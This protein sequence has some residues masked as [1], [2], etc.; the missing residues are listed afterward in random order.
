[1]ASETVRVLLVEDGLANQKLAVGMLNRWGHTVTVAENGAVGV[2]MYQAGEFDLVFMDLQMPVMDGL[3]ATQRIRETEA[4]TENH[5]PI[6]AMTAHALVGDR[7]R[8]IKAGMDHY[9]SKPIRI[10]DLALAIGMFHHPEQ[11]N[12]QTEEIDVPSSDISPSAGINL[13]ETLEMMEDDRSILIS[14]VQAFITEAPILLQ[15]FR[16][17][18]EAG[19]RNVAIRSAHTLKGNFGILR[20]QAEQEIWQQLEKLAREGSFNEMREPAEQAHN[21]SLHVLKQL[22]EF[23]EQEG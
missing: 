14:V 12:D 6:I 2:E 3:E 16:D 10:K 13:D 23:I 11:L 4:G 21:M 22:R 1:M 7:E 18:I 9:V 20:Q 19:D 17:A 8:C 15:R 5:V